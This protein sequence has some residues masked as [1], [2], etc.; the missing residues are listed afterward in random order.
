MRSKSLW[1]LIHSFNNYFLSS[2][3]S[4]ILLLLEKYWCLDS[5][6]SRSTEGE[7][8]MSNQS[9]HSVVNATTEL[10]CKTQCGPK[11]QVT[12]CSWRVREVALELSLELA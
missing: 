1:E 7:G 10:V 4:G 12:A 2:C 3:S 9:P 8:Q 11:E 5:Q 6:S